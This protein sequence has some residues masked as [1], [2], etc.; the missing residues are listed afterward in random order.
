MACLQICPLHSTYY[1]NL[2]SRPSSLCLSYW[3]KQVFCASV[4]LNSTSAFQKK[5]CITPKQLCI[6]I[7]ENF[8]I[9]CSVIFCFCRHTLPSGAQGS[10]SDLPAPPEPGLTGPSHITSH[11]SPDSPSH[12]LY[13]PRPHHPHYYITLSPTSCLLLLQTPFP[14]KDQSIFM[15]WEYNLSF[16]IST[17]KIIFIYLINNL[18]QSLLLFYCRNNLSILKLFLNRTCLKK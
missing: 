7:S 16:E 6:I 9:F 12:L 8:P 18:L 1:A 3:Q 17:K 13:L 2:L 10:L 4:C 5:P 11:S 14:Q 15:A